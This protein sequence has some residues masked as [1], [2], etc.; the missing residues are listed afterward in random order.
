MKLAVRGG[1]I[2][3]LHELLNAGADLSECDKSGRN[4]LTLQE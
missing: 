4:A 3:I 2:Q 1:D